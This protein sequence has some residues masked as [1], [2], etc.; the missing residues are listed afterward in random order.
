MKSRFRFTLIELLV[1][2][3]IIAILAAMLL[4]ALNKARDKAQTISCTSQQKQMAHFCATYSSDNNEYVTPARL[5]YETKKIWYDCLFVYSQMFSRVAKTSKQK[6]V[7]ASPMCPAALKEEGSVTS[8]EGLFALW[9][10]TGSINPWNCGPY[11]L[12]SSNGN[13]DPADPAS[14]NLMAQFAAFKKLSQCKDVSHKIQFMD[15]YIS[16]LGKSYWDNAS[17]TNVA[18]NRHGSFANISFQDGH[19]GTLQKISST[20]RLGANQQAVYYYTD[21]V[22]MP[23]GFE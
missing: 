9:T 19:A 3:A 7:I 1:V 22:N 13:L 8:A 6:R 20:A 2:I 14:R 23:D 10:E 4:P 16:V 5:K 21:L 11:A 17:T 18:W 15:S 12:W